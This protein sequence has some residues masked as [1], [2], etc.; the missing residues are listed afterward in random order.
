MGFVDN[1]FL[2]ACKKFKNLFNPVVMLFGFQT[3]NC[4][5]SRSIYPNSDSEVSEQT[6]FGFFFLFKVLLGIQHFQDCVILLLSESSSCLFT[7]L[8]TAVGV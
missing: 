8:I 6:W 4:P 7:V 2:S 1:Y 5:C 3:C